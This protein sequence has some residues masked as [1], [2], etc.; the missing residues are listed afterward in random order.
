[1]AKLKQ[2]DENEKKRVSGLFFDTKKHLVLPLNEFLELILIYVVYLCFN[3]LF[4]AMR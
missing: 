1:M 2:R 4:L 3:I